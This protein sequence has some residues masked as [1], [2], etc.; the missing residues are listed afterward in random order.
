[1]LI[2]LDIDSVYEDAQIQ[3]APGDTVVYFTDGFTDAMSQSGDRFDEDRFNT[4]FEWA[5]QEGYG[6]QAILDHLFDQVQRF[7]GDGDTYKD[8]MTLVVLQ[9]EASQEG[10]GST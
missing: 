1:M 5:C 2:G 10:Q 4:A 7:V 9:L 8:D 6:A 3:L